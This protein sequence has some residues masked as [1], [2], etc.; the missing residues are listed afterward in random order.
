ML[1]IINAQH[2]HMAQVVS[3]ATTI[4]FILSE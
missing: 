4:S 2:L 1:F 3:S